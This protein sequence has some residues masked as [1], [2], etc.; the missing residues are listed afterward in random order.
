MLHLILESLTCAVCSSTLATGTTSQNDS[1]A[2]ADEPPAPA[3]T[4]QPPGR[5]AVCDAWGY[6]LTW[7]TVC[8]SHDLLVQHASCDGG[9]GVSGFDS[10]D[11]S[12]VC[13]CQY[14]PVLIEHLADCRL[15]VARWARSCPVPTCGV[16]WRA[17]CACGYVFTSVADAFDVW[18]QDGR[19]RCVA[20]SPSE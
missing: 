14:H 15:N 16:C 4:H 2:D 12:E 7:G 18:P 3:E 5:S 11:D 1:P 10:D 20:C 17:S 6:D 13:P 8:S 9:G 19:L